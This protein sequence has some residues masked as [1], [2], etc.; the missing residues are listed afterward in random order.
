MAANLQ[1]ERYQVWANKFRALAHPARLQLLSLLA[2]RPACVYELVKWAGYRQPYISQQLAVLREAEL[3]C[4]ERDGLRCRYY[5][6]YPELP[7]LLDKVSQLP[8]PKQFAR[9]RGKPQV[10]EM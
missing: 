3:V 2:Q 4:T 6:A 8:A 5:L 9:T 1:D 10:N 7:V